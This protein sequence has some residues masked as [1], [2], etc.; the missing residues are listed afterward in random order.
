VAIETVF[1]MND[2]PALMPPAV[3]VIVA[4]PVPTAVTSVAVESTAGTVATAALPLT[5][6]TLRP[7]SGCP[8]ASVSATLTSVVPPG[9][10][11][12]PFGLNSSAA[13]G[14][15]LAAHH[16]P[17]TF[18]VGQVKVPAR[19]SAPPCDFRRGRTHRS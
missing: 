15:T 13:G 19:L 16:E 5:Q 11:V 17:T 9:T 1:T 6:L 3:A 2:A 14:P 12:R 7:S 18:V 10:I 4:A 8:A